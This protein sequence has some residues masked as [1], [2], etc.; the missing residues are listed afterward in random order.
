[1]ISEHLTALDLPQDLDSSLESM[2][3]RLSTMYCGRQYT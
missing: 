2:S 3:R 1:M